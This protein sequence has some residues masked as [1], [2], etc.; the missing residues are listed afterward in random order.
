[1]CVFVCVLC[2]AVVAVCQYVSFTTC[3]L[4]FCLT[5]AACSHFCLMVFIRG[6]GCNTELHICGVFLNDQLHTANDRK[7]YF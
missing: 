6:N 4:W 2:L 3:P 1:M 7:S 5:F